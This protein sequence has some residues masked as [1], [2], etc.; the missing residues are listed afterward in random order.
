MRDFQSFREHVLSGLSLLKG[1]QRP[2]WNKTE[3]EDWVRKEYRR[4]YGKNK[5]SRS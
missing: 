2:I 3:I 4:L 5:E 1:K